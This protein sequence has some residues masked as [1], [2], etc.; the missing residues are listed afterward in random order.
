[1]EY[2]MDGEYAKKVK[3]LLI[4]DWAMQ[5]GLW[6]HPQ[7]QYQGLPMMFTFEQACAAEKIALTEWSV[8]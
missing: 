7:R 6:V 2:V 8:N 1:M 5:D 4:R 3:S